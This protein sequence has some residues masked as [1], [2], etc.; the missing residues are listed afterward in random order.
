WKY[1]ERAFRYC[2][3]DLGHA[4]AAIGFSA[5]I[6]GWRAVVLPTW[7]QASIATLTGIDREE[8]LVEAEREE[9]GCIIAIAPPA[10]HPVA[11]NGSRPREYVRNG[12]WPD[13]ASQM[14][15]DHGQLTFIGAYARATCHA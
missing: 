6:A 12:R 14:S 10:A 9:P 1:G 8:D 5:A 11:S 4:I 7:S 3:H 15:E 13:R 2:Q